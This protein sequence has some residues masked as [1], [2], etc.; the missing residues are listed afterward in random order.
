M[1]LPEG[2]A[3]ATRCVAFGHL[4][5]LCG[6]EPILLGV[7][8]AMV[9]TKRGFYEGLRYELLEFPEIKAVGRKR[10]LRQRG[11]KKE[12]GK[13]LTQNCTGNDTK[14]VLAFGLRTELSWLTNICSEIDI[15]LIK[16]VCEWFDKNQFEGISGI[17]KLL[18][19]RIG[20][21][22]WNPKCKNIIAISRLFENYYNKRNCHTIRVPTILDT[23]RFKVDESYFDKEKSEKLIMAYAGSPVKKD[24]IF[25]VP[26]ALLMLNKEE[27][28]K[29]QVNLYG[30]TWEYFD[31]HG[32]TE[33]D[34]ITLNNCLLCHGRVP[35]S[36]IK[37]E[38]NNAD[39]TILLRP[40][41]RYANA[42]FPT[43]VGE[44]MAMG[45]PVIANIT[46]DLDLYLHDGIEGLV[47]KDE[48]PSSCAEA[49]RRALLLS[50]AERICMRNAA[51]KQAEKSFD[52]RAYKDIFEAFLLK[53][54][55]L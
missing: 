12:V 30:V 19:D 39:F 34:R 27:R 3:G 51:R 42:G 47:C 2:S 40:K 49:F 41:K 38:L 11:L 26:H 50:R 23:Q 31:R 54:K 15:P 53:L 46:S 16:D 9:S 20:L 52:Y 29:I 32:F 8:Y 14:C 10:Y 43:K 55:Y 45:V 18:E 37:E 44:S 6:Y 7:N 24:Y 33:E 13:W 36:V 22:Y 48:T 5:K 28:E 21:H 1:D 35:Y 4:A 17:V 25:N